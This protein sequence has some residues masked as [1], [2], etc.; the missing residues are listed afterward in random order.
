MK[1]SDID[2]VNHLVAALE[3]VKAL[4]AT[5]SRAEA[6]AFG[7]FI[8]APGDTS[9]RMSDEGA[10]TA[11]SRGIGVSTGFLAKVK[12]LAVA[13]LQSHQ[14]TILTELAAL[15]IDTTP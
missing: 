7:V 1:L 3:D 6:N 8:D 2:R 13:E 4:I 5:A 12:Q 10:S 11:H 9:L 14:K 15:G